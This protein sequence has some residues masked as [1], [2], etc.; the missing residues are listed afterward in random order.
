MSINIFKNATNCTEFAPG[1]V[2]FEE[3][4]PGDVMYAVVEGTV[5]VVLGG[6]TI[7]KVEAGGIL[8]ELAL[9]DNSPRGATAVA[10]SAAR[11]APVDKRHF[12]FLVQEHPTFALQVMSVM[13]D[14]L[15]QANERE[16][17]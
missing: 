5:D 10:A 13:A 9:V 3:G 15:R 6:Q 4:A 16:R 14:R 11:L 1:E 8:G 2:I 12:T 7:E 17:A